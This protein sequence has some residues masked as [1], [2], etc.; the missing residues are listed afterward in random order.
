MADKYQITSQTPTTSLDP[1]TMGFKEVWEIGYKV[2]DG[3]AKGTTGKLTVPEEDHN[4]AYVDAAIRDKL[5]DL[6]N[7]AGLGEAPVSQ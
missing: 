5:K 7:I 3:A 4:A 6:H 2:T 1:S